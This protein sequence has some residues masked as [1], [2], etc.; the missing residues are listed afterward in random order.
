MFNKSEYWLELCDDDI[1]VARNL[2][3]SKDWLWMSFICH[4][5][6]E[7]SLKSV[8]ADKTSEEPKRIHDL[9]KLAEQAGIESEL[10]DE[11]KDFLEELTPYNIE[12]RY[13]SYKQKMASKL[14]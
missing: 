14:S 4:L 10:S 7:K 2:L 3:K 1:P 5:I 12:A 11:Q 6:V 13:P 8:I 9:A